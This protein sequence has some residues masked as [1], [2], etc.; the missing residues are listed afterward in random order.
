MKDEGLRSWLGEYGRAWENRDAA[1]AGELFTDDAS[2]RESPFDE[3][4]RGRAA[5]IEYWSDNV[6]SQ[7]EIRFDYEILSATER[8]GIAR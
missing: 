3:P 4:V 7:E 2:Y 1:A 8:G 6:K 5:I